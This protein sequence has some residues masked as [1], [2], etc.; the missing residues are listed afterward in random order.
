MEQPSGCKLVIFDLDYTIM[1][2]TTGVFFDTASHVLPLLKNS[3]I[4]I[5]LA[6]LNN[7]ATIHLINNHANGFFDCVEERKLEGDCLNQEELEE[8]RSL[9]KDKMIERILSKL[10]V[11]PSKTLFFDDQ[12]AHCLVA[13]DMGIRSVLVD[14]ETGVTWNDICCGLMMF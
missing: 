10:E 11:V 12:P 9:M 2:P 5:A 7:F 3:G 13:Q 1:D 6:S 8:T 14:P 4:K